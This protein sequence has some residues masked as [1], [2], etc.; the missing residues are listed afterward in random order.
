MPH[1]WQVATDQ[2]SETKKKSPQLEAACNV[3]Y[4]SD[5]Y[6]EKFLLPNVNA[7][8]CKKRKTTLTKK[9]TAC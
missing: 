8:G 4:N 5:F 3:P 1:Q 2:C 6:I 7:S 9:F